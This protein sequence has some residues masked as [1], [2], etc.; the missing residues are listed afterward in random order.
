MP[1]RKVP[2][3]ERR[4]QIL[5]AAAAVAQADGLSGLTVRR[6]AEAA[7]VS[8]GLVLFHYQSM[9]ALRAALLDWL[10]ER[11]LRLDVPALQARWPDPRE[12]LHAMLG[13][14]L[15]GAD[16][17]RPEIALLLAYWI[18]SAQEPE[19]RS[20]LR[21]ALANYTADVQR[22]VEEALD[23]HEQSTLMP[24]QLAAVLVRAILSRGLEAALDIELLDAPAQQM[25]VRLMIDG[26]TLSPPASSSPGVH[27]DSPSSP[28]DARRDGS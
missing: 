23:N 19:I 6:V 3:Q 26:A 8:V 7:G 24:A 28:G 25:M 5:R 1:G 10:L 14:E 12:R 4:E 15:A 16:G 22:L 17:V 20:R 18:Q 9:D 2:E 13:D 27:G 11:T 21:R